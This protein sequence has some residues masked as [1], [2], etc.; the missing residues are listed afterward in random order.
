M[1]LIQDLC[2]GGDVCTVMKSRPS[3]PEEEAAQ[4]I[5]S[6]LLSVNYLH[7]RG[8]VHR[9]INSSNIVFPKTGSLHVRLIDFGSSADTNREPIPFSVPCS[10]KPQYIAPEVFNLDY[11]EKCDIWSV[12]IVTYEILSKNRPFDNYSNDHQ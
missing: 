1:H 3:F 6:L 7:K 10:N 5:K 12:G 2:L 8:I 9:G 11:S 4:I